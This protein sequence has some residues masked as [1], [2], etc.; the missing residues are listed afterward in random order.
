MS[1]YIYINYFKKINI[2]GIYCVIILD[3]NISSMPFYNQTLI[4]KFISINVL[5]VSPN[6]KRLAIN[7]EI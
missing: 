6:L 4:I 1:I 3:D 5:L 7:E 2:F